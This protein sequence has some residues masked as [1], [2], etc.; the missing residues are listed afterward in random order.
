MEGLKHAGKR[1]DKGIGRLLKQNT[2]L[3]MLEDNSHSRNHDVNDNLKSA[4]KRAEG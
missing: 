2:S 3:K 4:V 1:I